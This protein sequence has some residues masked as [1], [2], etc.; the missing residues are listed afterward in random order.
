MLSVLVLFSAIFLIIDHASSPYADPVPDVLIDENLAETGDSTEE[1]IIEG[2]SGL[3][4]DGNHIP[5]I[6][7]EYSE[8]DLLM[9]EISLEEFA[10]I[11]EHNEPNIIRTPNDDVVVDNDV[12]VIEVTEDGNPITAIDETESNDVIDNSA[13]VYEDVETHDENVVSVD[14][15]AESNEEN[16]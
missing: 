16:A 4:G 13:E 5:V 12:P 7:P 2:A 9:M 3:I 11:W 10:A 6:I 1:T 15:E 14:E 8:D